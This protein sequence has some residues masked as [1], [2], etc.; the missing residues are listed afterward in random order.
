MKTDNI[1]DGSEPSMNAFAAGISRIGERNPKF[2]SVRA[3]MIS[4]LETAGAGLSAK[5]FAVIADN[6]PFESFPKE[7]KASHKCA[8]N[9]CI[10][11]NTL[12]LLETPYSLKHF[13]PRIG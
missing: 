6:S 5:S 7:I 9:I 4:V 11:S 3:S 10:R 12:Y 8:V 1:I 2:S 13:L